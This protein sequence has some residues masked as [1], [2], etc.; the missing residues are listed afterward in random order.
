MEA[1]IINPFIQAS[2]E[3]LD[4]MASI[5]PVPG[6][7]YLKKNDMAI[8]DVSGIIGFTGYAQGS[9]SITFEES[10]ILKIVTNMF[11]EEVTEMTDEVVDAV[12]EI[13]NIIS[14]HA[15]RSLDE[16][17]IHFQ[18]SVPSIITGNNHKIKHITQGPK[19]AIPFTTDNGGFTIEVS[20]DQ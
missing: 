20:L 3:V 9:V 14:G 4:T 17:G 15:R 10:C 11:G 8:G 2:L 19:I 13:T 1:K 7:P 18:G 12:G 6:K 16:K 5:K